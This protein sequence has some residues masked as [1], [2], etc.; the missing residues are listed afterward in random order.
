[1]NATND[2]GSV[3]DPSTNDE[4][5]DKKAH[6]RAF[7][8][9]NADPADPA[10]LKGTVPYRTQRTIEIYSNPHT[11]REERQI[12]LVKKSH[13]LLSTCAE[14]FVGKLGELEKGE[15]LTNGLPD[16]YSL[17][18]GCYIHTPL[19]G[20]VMP[21]GKP[22]LTRLTPDDDGYLCG[23]M[24]VNL[25]VATKLVPMLLADY[26]E[27]TFSS[28]KEELER[29]DPNLPYKLENPDALDDEVFIDLP[30][31]VLEYRVSSRF[32]SVNFFPP[33]SGVKH[34]LLEIDIGQFTPIRA[35][36]P[37][38]EKSR[39]EA[40]KQNS[41]GWEEFLKSF[42]KRGFREFIGGMYFDKNGASIFHKPSGG[43]R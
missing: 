40:A 4:G 17:H 5:V 30:E 2:N 21:D 9:V 38:D 32:L 28:T 35:D 15:I 16:Y 27:K 29:A 19:V 24:E 18:N 25:R 34:N 8:V 14:L 10:V 43:R 11:E 36:N 23:K 37:R 12:L 26:R 42:S 1:M 33:D 41:E 6:Q 39:E 13:V 31:R 7:R 3:S 20:I 22:G